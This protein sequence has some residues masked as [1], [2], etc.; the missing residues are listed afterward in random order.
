MSRV[1]RNKRAQ[2]P[3]S[4]INRIQVH[5]RVARASLKQ[6]LK[7]PVSCLVTIFVIAASLLLPA[8]LFGLNSNLS[9]IL[10]GFQ[11]NAQVTLY[12]KDEVRKIS[13]KRISDD[14][15]TCPDINTSVY[16]SPEQALDEFASSTGLESLLQELSSNPLP[17]T[18][19]V[20]AADASP[21]SVD[22]LVQ[23]LHTIPE[24]ALVQVDSRWLQR[25]A[26]ISQLIKLIGQLLSVVVITA[27]FLVIGNTIKL[28][29][30]NRKEE[31]RVIKLVG[32]SDMFAARPF[33]YTG[34]LYGLAGGVLA[35]LLQHVVLY[36]FNSGFEQLMQLYSSE[37]KLQGFGLNSSLIIIAA[38]SAI[39]WVAAFVTSLRQ[40]RNINL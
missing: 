13:G 24:I 7:S 38:G 19:I 26:A 14:L 11:E 23:Q 17:G 25:L 40:I 18:I 1:Q 31:I 32:G 12:L 35:V 22:S 39:S 2:P 27:L 37:F 3:S 8:L 21:A 10:S 9:S 29:I 15:L 4:Y 30:E 34:L 36:A 33:L 20:T 5:K 6:L 28:A 16:I